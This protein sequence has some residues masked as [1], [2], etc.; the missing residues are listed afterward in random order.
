MPVCVL[1]DVVEERHLAAR[2]PTACFGDVLERVCEPSLCGELA[3][4]CQ[5]GVGTE[6]RGPRE[7]EGRHVV[8]D[9]CLLEFAASDPSVMAFHVSLGSAHEFEEVLVVETRHEV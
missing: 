1:G 4:R 9:K 7:V 8:A 5:F 3:A 6:A 2:R